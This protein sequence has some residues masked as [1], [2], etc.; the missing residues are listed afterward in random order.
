MDYRIKVFP[1]YFLPQSI[2]TIGGFL[3]INNSPNLKIKKKHNFNSKLIKMVTVQKN[4]TRS[5]PSPSKK[6]VEGNFKSLLL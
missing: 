3:F 5:A 4:Q 1:K 6:L 2:F